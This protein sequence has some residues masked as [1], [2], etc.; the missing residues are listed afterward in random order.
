MPDVD[1][2]A[3]LRQVRALPPEQGGRVPAAAITAY[4]R[5]MDREAALRAGFDLHL[6]K[7]LRAEMVVEAVATLVSRKAGAR[8]ASLP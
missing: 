8:G 4:A 1:G 6:A 3:L 2:Y 5:D 7:P